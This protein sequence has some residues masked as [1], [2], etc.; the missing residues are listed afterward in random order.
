MSKY[1]QLIIDSEVEEFDQDETKDLEQE[2]SDLKEPFDPKD[3]EIQVLQTT[4][5]TLI[6]RL[7]NNEIDLSPDFQRTADLWR[8]ELKGRLIESLF[9]RLPLPAFYFDATNDEHWQVVDGLQRLTTIKRF[10]LEKGNKKLALKGLEFMRDY[11]GAFYDDLPRT[12]QRR[13]NEAPVTLYLIKPATPKEVKYSLFYRINTGGLT[14]NA[15]EIRHALSQSTNEGKASKFLKSLTETD[16]FK[17]VVRAPDKRML[18]KELVLRFCAFKITSFN[19]YKSP[20][21]KF[22][23]STMDSL[24]EDLTENQLRQLS[25]SFEGSLLLSG[26]LFGKDAFRKSLVDKDKNKVLNRA[27]FE[28]ITV[29]FSSLTKEHQEKLLANKSEFIDD[30][31]KLMSSDDF[32]AAISYSTTDTENVKYRFNCILELINKF[33]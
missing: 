24:G 13:I 11:E 27:L 31:K 16:I 6:T 9:I 5:S 3:I 8:N 26:E 17:K 20:M 23:N 22:L 18:D 4:M 2:I 29:L 10:V 12:L 14:L 19:N 30:F 1:E 28:V 25:E 15:Q 7:D 32:F 21:I 33:S